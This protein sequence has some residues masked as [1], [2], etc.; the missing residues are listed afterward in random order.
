MS[1]PPRPARPAGVRPAKATDVRG[2]VPC[3][4]CG[5]P[6]GQ[7]CR[8][9]AGNPLTGPGAGSPAVHFGRLR[10]YRRAYP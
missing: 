8:D 6:A 7:L 1:T 4:V 3:P 10:E 9:K 2:K 5:A